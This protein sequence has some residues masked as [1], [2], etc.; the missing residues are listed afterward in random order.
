VWVVGGKPLV[1]G[2][3]LGMVASGFVLFLL[4]R[5]V[6]SSSPD[7]P[8]EIVSPD[9]G[10]AVNP[11]ASVEVRMRTLTPGEHPL[12]FVRPIPDD[13]NQDYFVQ[14]SLKPIGSDRWKLD[15]VGVGSPEDPPGQPF[16]ICAVITLENMERGDRLRVLPQGEH[17]CID[18]VRG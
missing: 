2:F 10:S 5:T 18:V 16:K 12:V 8:I 9:N 17:D 6:L 7:D 13:E 3:F 11:V 1:L 15:A 4:A 14:G